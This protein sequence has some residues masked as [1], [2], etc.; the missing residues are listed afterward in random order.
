M[1]NSEGEIT[2][3]VEYKRDELLVH[4]FCPVCDHAEKATD[5]GRDKEQAATDATAKIKAHINK[6][7]GAR[8]TKRNG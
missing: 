4:A 6:A 5:T 3:L 1:N 7:H 2:T 8:L